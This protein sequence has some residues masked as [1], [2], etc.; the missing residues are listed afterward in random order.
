MEEP[1]DSKID[2]VNDSKGN[3]PKGEDDE[4][5]LSHLTPNEIFLEAAEMYRNTY[6]P[7]I[8]F[9]FRLE[10]LFVLEDQPDI[11]KILGTYS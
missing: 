9:P 5:N 11:S 7:S 2:N 8:P 3:Q 6:G 4:A 1:E 10:R